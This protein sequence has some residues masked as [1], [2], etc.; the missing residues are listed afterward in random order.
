MD[1]GEL[2]MWEVY[3]F[4][5][6]LLKKFWLIFMLVMVVSEGLVDWQFVGQQVCVEC[7][8]QGVGVYEGDD[9]Y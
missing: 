3:G 4:D 7:V 9:C 8:I 2:F 6:G 5:V 1:F